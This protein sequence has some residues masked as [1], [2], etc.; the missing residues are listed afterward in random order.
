MVPPRLQRSA[1]TA[2]RAEC[3]LCGGKAALSFSKLGT[4]KVYATYNEQITELTTIK[5]KL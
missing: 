4:Y 5:V 1:S 2:H 3:T